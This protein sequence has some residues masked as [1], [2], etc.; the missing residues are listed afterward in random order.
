M[1]CWGQRFTVAPHAVKAWNAYIK[2]SQQTITF[3]EV[4]VG[5]KIKHRKR[6]LVVETI[7]TVGA[8]IMLGFSNGMNFGGE[9]DMT[10][11]IKIDTDAAPFLAKIAK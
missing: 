1:Q 11:E 10:V 5:D 4:K 3:A 6:W 2:A 9:A 8:N 7:S